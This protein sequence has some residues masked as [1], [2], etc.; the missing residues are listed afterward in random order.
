MRGQESEATHLPGRQTRVR[1]HGQRPSIL[2]LPAVGPR[3]PSAG[4]GSDSR[5]MK[6]PDRRFRTTAFLK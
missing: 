1:A 3:G 2:M 4:K 6:Q 5:E